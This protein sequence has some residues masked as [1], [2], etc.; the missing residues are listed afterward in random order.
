MINVFINEQCSEPKSPIFFRQKY[1]YVKES[2]HRPLEMM[3]RSLAI[4]LLIGMQP[5]FRSTETNSQDLLSL[6]TKQT[7][8]GEEP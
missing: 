7:V 5:T 3:S 8:R 1:M 2:Y 6:L 4:F